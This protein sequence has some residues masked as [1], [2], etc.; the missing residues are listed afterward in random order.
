MIRMRTAIQL[1]SF[2]V[3]ASIL[4]TGYTNCSPGF[5]VSDLTQFSNGSLNTETGDPILTAKSQAILRSSRCNSCHGTTPGMGEIY[6]FDIAAL[7]AK[8]RIVPGQ[9]T[10]S[11]VYLN[12]AGTHQ[13]TPSLALSDRQTLA[14]WIASMRATPITPAPTP[15]P[16]PVPGPSATSQPPALPSGTKSCAVIASM[17]SNIVPG[18]LV[19]FTVTWTG[20]SLSATF[21]GAPFN[22]VGV[23]TYTTS[24]QILMSRGYTAST[25][26]AAGV[27]VNCSVNV[28]LKPTSNLTKDEFFRAK[29][30]PVNQSVSDLISVN[31]CANCHSSG[32][33]TANANAIAFVNIRANDMLGNLSRIKNVNLMNGSFLDLTK[34]VSGAGGLYQYAVGHM[35]KVPA[36]TNADKAFIL[37]YINRP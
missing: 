21:D 22:S 14:D 29:I 30:G 13:Q 9:P 24:Q 16:N 32:G 25:Q 17:S 5:A 2:V 6:L 28:F 31:R 36:Y 37:D 11:S 1:I 15:I 26:D 27:T 33:S 23:S 4:S 35:T 12:T 7:I 34:A 18:E 19:T 10:L 8:G 3:T 20:S